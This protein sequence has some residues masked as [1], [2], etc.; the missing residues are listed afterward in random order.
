LS[1]L[2]LRDAG[3]GVPPRFR[4]A[5][6]SLD[7]PYSSNPGRRGR[8]PRLG[9]P[10]MGLCGLLTTAAGGTGGAIGVGMRSGA[11]WIG[12]IGPSSSSS[13]W[14]PLLYTL[15]LV[16]TRLS[17]GA[18]NFWAWCVCWAL[19]SVFSN[20]SILID[21]LCCRG[22]LSCRVSRFALTFWIMGRANCSTTS[23]STDSLRIEPD[24]EVT[25]EG[26]VKVEMSGSSPCLSG[27]GVCRALL[28][29]ISGSGWN[30]TGRCSFGGGLFSAGLC[31]RESPTPGVLSGGLGDRSASG[32]G[33][34]GPEP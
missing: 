4:K 14:M 1:V 3:V 17:S 16:L 30:T 31:D 32:K 12:R 2:P 13:S 29:G 6:W 20:S 24:G 10:R 9:G 26:E 25:V 8:G 15:L 34:S 7:T 28:S 23:S 27:G 33:P 21:K 19:R 22:V 5:T 18:G 11:G